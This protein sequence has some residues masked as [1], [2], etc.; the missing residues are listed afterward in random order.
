MPG[1]KLPHMQLVLRNL[2]VLGTF[3]LMNELLKVADQETWSHWWETY[4][5]HTGFIEGMRAKG[6]GEIRLWT[7]FIA[8][9]WS[10]WQGEMEEVQ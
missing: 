3:P 7:I 1:L 10:R 2:K 9:S 6:G 4:E 5:A 8:H